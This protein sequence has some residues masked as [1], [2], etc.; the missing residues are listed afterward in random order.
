VPR[1]AVLCLAE[2]DD[3]RLVQ[4]AAVLAADSRAVW[5]A[6]AAPLLASLPAQVRS[7]VEL[8]QDWTAPE[9]EFDAV[10]FHGATPQLFALQHQLARRPGAIVSVERLEPGATDVPLERLMTERSLSVNTAAAG[11][12]ASLMTIG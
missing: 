11:G 6:S 5:P 2:R 1:Q 9:V 12:N 8:A 4:L 7:R 3:D 10:L